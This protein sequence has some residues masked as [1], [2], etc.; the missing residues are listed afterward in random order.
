VFPAHRLTLGVLLCVLAGA[1]A[2]TKPN[3]AYGGVRPGDADGRASDG[4]AG[5]DTS[6]PVGPSDAGGGASD[7]RSSGDGARAEA[8]GADGG[9]QPGGDGGFVLVD[10]SET[11]LRGGS[12]GVKYR[13][14]C[15]EPDQ[16]LIGLAGTVIDRAA[17]PLGIGSLS[18][19][20]GRLTLAPSGAMFRILVEG[21]TALPTRGKMLEGPWTSTCPANEVV[22]GID[23]RAGGWID[24]IV[25]VCAPLLVATDGS[26]M[27][28]QGPMTALP[29]QG[30]HPEG[31]SPFSD[32]CGAG[33][34]VYG[35]LIGAGDWIDG[36]NLLC[37]APR[38]PY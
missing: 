24:E 18:G 4:G 19:L 13:D 30:G 22:V 3:P 23:G 33:R 17:D 12:G 31:G 26:R 11:P 2:C 10:P 20:C 32:R 35:V 7:T 36:L 9:R 38:A 29:P 27:V 25:V 6:L 1:G 21:A 16:V 28:T 8:G 14:S 37:A 5:G 15:A 34:A